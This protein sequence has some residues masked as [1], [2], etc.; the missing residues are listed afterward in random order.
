M[1]V[2]DRILSIVAPHECV[3]CG[4]EGVVL[5]VECTERLPY[6]PAGIC[7]LCGRL[8]KNYKVCA[9]CADSTALQHVYVVAQYTDLAKTLVAK[10]KFDNV[11]AGA[12]PIAV[13]MHEA[14]PYFAEPPIVT[15]VP[16]MPQ[17]ARIRGFDHAQLL[18]KELAYQR[19]W[20]YAP[21][22]LRQKSLQQH[23]ATRTE[24]QRQIKGAFRAVAADRIKGRHVLLVDDVV[25]TG[26]TITE[27]ARVLKKVGAQ[28]IDAVVFARTPEK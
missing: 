15:F 28:R 9:K 21:Q 4:A 13:T 23:G 1:N 18:A 22:L 10:Y 20:H 2:I 26:A 25:T 17:H 24:R 7:Y 16:T 27:A 8:S 3:G 5:C 14:L 19:G 12:P 11:R 6:L